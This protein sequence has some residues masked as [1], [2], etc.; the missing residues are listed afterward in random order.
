MTV[1]YKAGDKDNRPW[2]TWEVVDVG[3]NYIVKKICVNPGQTLSLQMH[4]HRDEHWIITSGQAT[5]TL[6]EKQFDAS[7]NTPVFIKAGQ[8]HRIA[9]KT[10]QPVIF[11][12]I[13]TGNTLDEND[14]VRFEDQY[15]RTFPQ[16]QE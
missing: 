7:E 8:K 10:E 1:S 16:K 11:I 6:G 3:E 5:I 4:H 14:I 15:G 12:E 2:G 13:Q 9:N